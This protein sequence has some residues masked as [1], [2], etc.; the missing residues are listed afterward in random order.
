MKYIVHNLSRK[1]IFIQSYN[2]LLLVLVLFCSGVSLASNSGQTF[3][4]EEGMF[5]ASI[6]LILLV[7]GKF[8]ML[9]AKLV[10]KDY[11][12]W[13]GPP[14]TFG[15]VFTNLKSAITRWVFLKMIA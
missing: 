14:T 2:N 9:F 8:F 1:K 12:I 3:L 5:L 10:K 13:F 6:P 15:K 11:S 7:F 4:L